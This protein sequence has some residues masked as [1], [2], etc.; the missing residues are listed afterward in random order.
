MAAEFIQDRATAGNVGSEVLRLLRDESYHAERRALLQEVRER[1]G[2]GGGARNAAA[3]ALS[4]L[5]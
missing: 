1:L 2:S 3:A 5:T 4:L